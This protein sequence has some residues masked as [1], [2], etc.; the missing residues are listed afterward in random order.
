MEHHSHEISDS[1]SV[2]KTISIKELFEVIVEEEVDEN[3]LQELSTN[4]KI[5]RALSMEN[6]VNDFDSSDCIQEGS[7]VAEFNTIIFTL[8]KQPIVVDKLRALIRDKL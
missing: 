4:R 3:L 1:N 8:R 2:G 6:A 7:T 5:L